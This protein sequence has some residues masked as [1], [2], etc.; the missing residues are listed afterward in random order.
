MGIG[1]LS[2]AAKVGHVILLIQASP[3]ICVGI[4]DVVQVSIFEP[5]AA[6]DTRSGNFVT[7]PS[8]AV[9]ARGLFTVPFAGDIKAAGRPLSEIR[10]EIETKL[11]KRAIE[12]RVEVALIKQDSPGQCLR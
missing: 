4:G 10:H 6:G 3:E 2:A 5:S 7:L 12:P 9:D 11:A 1:S 8:Q